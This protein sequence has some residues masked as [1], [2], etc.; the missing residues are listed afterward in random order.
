MILTKP[1]PHHSGFSMK[2]ASMS[3][4]WIDPVTLRS[5][6]ESSV[7]MAPLVSSAVRAVLS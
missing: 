1:S 5:S 4:S 2:N 3:E 6:H 7:L